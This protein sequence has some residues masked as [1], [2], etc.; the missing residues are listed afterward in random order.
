MEISGGDVEERRRGATGDTIEKV[1]VHVSGE[2]DID[3]PGSRLDAW[4]AVRVAPGTA[5]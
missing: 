3:L 5:S 4:R 1:I 2:A